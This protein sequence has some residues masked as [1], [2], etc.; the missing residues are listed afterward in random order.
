LDF[1][2]EEHLDIR[3]IIPASVCRVFRIK[4]GVSKPENTITVETSG[5]RFTNGGR[6]SIW[7]GSA[8][9]DFFSE[10]EEH[11]DRMQE[12]ITTELDLTVKN[13]RILINPQCRA[14]FNEHF[15]PTKLQH[16]VEDEDYYLPEW[17]G[18]IRCMETNKH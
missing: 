13:W 1:E 8:T 2:H 6:A 5:D 17:L 9:V 4:R 12:Y 10:E 15:K 16:F 11:G 14:C 18:D 3:S 7:N